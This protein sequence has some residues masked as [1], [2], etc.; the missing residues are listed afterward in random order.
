MKI[1]LLLYIVLSAHLSFAAL[2]FA[3]DLPFEGHP[4]EYHSDNRRFFGLELFELHAPTSSEANKKYTFD[5]YEKRS[6]DFLGYTLLLIRNNAR[7][8][9]K[10]KP[11]SLR[12]MSKIL[13]AAELDYLAIHANKGVLPQELLDGVKNGPDRFLDGRSTY[14]LIVKGSAEDVVRWA[15]SSEPFPKGKFMASLRISNLSLQYPMLPFAM[16]LGA[17]PKSLELP[18]DN[19][20]VKS[21][22]L[23]PILSL[24]NSI[25]F[26]YIHPSVLE[27]E[28]RYVSASVGGVWGANEVKAF[29]IKRE[30]RIDWLPYLAQFLEGNLRTFESGV[31]YDKMT[32]KF[33]LSGDPQ[34]HNWNQNAYKK[35]Y[36]TQ[37]I[38][39][40]F[41]TSN[42]FGELM[43]SEYYAE[44]LMPSLEFQKYLMTSVAT[45][46][47]LRMYQALGFDVV[48]E[49]SK[50]L[51]NNPELTVAVMKIKREKWLSAVL[52]T[53][54]R[55][56]M[57]TLQNTITFKKSA[58]K[59]LQQLS[60]ERHSLNRGLRC[61]D[62]F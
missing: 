31:Y 27:V 26:P 30:S 50:Q 46:G 57:R 8:H 15:S 19:K 55:P 22:A 49:A 12:L 62:I 18:T 44:V 32:G 37:G 38:H 14:V 29:M 52:S 51:P 35:G 53:A 60:L 5:D 48:A 24:T 59:I 28:T 45:F 25:N 3:E 9:Q 21:P 16:N 39:G 58:P 42:R 4:S 17:N 2:E 7:S 33:L 13:S 20:S 54:G 43:V 40:P 23:Y 1:L 41:V 61:R 6:T 11:A 56:G 36:L 47:L 10:D 34:I